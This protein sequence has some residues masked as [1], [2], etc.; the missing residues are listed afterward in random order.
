MATVVNR[1][2]PSVLIYFDTP[3]GTDL[4]GMVTMAPESG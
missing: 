2:R 4:P 1:C 3:T